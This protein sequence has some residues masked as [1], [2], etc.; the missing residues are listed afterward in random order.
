[1]FHSHCS[2]PS[3]GHSV[4][5]SVASP[6]LQKIEDFMFEFGEI[7]GACPDFVHCFVDEGMLSEMGVTMR[8][9]PPKSAGV[10]PTLLSLNSAD[11]GYY[12]YR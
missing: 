8:Y 3:C 4:T 9:A 1:M 2:Y 11:R 7:E 10:P 12:H 5:A 6:L